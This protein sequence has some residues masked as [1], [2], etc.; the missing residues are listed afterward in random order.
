MQIS[1]SFRFGLFVCFIILLELLCLLA[2]CQFALNCVKVKS[3]NH[4]IKRNFYNMNKIA[5][6]KQQQTKK[7][8]DEHIKNNN[9][10]NRKQS[11]RNTTSGIKCARHTKYIQH[12]LLMWNMVG[13]VNSSTLYTAIIND[14]AKCISNK[15]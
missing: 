5:Q 13:I 10:N 12:T 15:K 4:R 3:D 1:D 14:Y 8:S 11:K 6:L 7:R 2:V 9:N